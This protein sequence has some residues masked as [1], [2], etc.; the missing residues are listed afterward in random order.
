MSVV[1]RR[2][3]DAGAVAPPAGVGAAA[4]A[5]A[6]TGVP[7]ITEPAAA[8]AA[9]SPLR[10]K[11][12]TAARMLILIRF[13]ERPLWRA[14]SSAKFGLLLAHVESCQFA[15]WSSRRWSTW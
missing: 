11:S 15:S 7:E 12:L 8:R 2:G 1:F 14:S 3:T 13:P 9:G 4:G 10:T 6:A 5:A